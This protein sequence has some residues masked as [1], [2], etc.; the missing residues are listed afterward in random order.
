MSV[1]LEDL[2]PQESDFAELASFCVM[3]PN[4]PLRH[5]AFKSNIQHSAL[6]LDTC[7]YGL[8]ALMA[9][10]CSQTRLLLGSLPAS[11]IEIR[12]AGQSE[13]ELR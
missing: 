6:S 10:L 4:L 12:E 13:F 9:F 7:K 11:L 5:Q 8:H 1:C 3:I 2:G